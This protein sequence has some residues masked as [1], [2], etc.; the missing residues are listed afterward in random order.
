MQELQPI[1][2]QYAKDMHVERF[3]FDRELSPMPEEIAAAYDNADAADGI[4]HD[5][6]VDRTFFGTFPNRF[7]LEP[8]GI[9]LSLLRL[10]KKDRPHRLRPS[11]GDY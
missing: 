8:A 11:T 9:G 2:T 3:L 6:N 7:A 10:W 4:S 5:R 1:F